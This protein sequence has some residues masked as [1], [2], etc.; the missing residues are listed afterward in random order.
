[1]CNFPAY[2]VLASLQKLSEGMAVIMV[3]VLGC[4]HTVLRT[5]EEVCRD[6][7]LQATMYLPHHLQLLT[8]KEFDFGH[9]GRNGKVPINLNYVTFWKVQN[10]KL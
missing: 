2:L 4:V 5:Q 1:M 8:G 7:N 6:Q 3:V 10:L 9:S